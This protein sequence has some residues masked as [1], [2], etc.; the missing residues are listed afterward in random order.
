MQ[1]QAS[2]A[3][4][5]GVTNAVREAN[6]Q[7]AGYVAELARVMAIGVAPSEFS[8]AHERLAKAGQRSILRSYDQ[9]VTRRKGPAGRSNYRADAAGRNRRYAGGL[10]RKALASPQ[11]IYWDER[12][13]ALINVSLLDREAAHWARLNAGAGPAGRGSRRTFQVQFGSLVVG[14]IGID[15]T[16]SSAF[17]IPRGYWWAPG[18]GPYSPNATRRGMDEFYP[19]KTGP[20]KRNNPG[21]NTSKVRFKARTAGDQNRLEGPSYQRRRPTRG[22]QA[23]NF[24]DAGAAT[25]AKELGPTY[26][27][28]YR[29]L[30]TKKLV[31]VKPSKIRASVR[32][33]RGGY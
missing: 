15:M 8:R 29:D 32:T 28:L 19:I 20:K 7:V 13:L 12:S 1:T 25:V 31:R 23:R 14:A 24:L 26:E 11:M 16:P 6:G 22:I 33:F 5:A 2:M 9:T 27:Q 4:A 30:Y 10:L 21:D 3:I 17:F 18:E